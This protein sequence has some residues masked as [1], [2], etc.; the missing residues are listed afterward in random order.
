M[1]K[2]TELKRT[3]TGTD[4]NEEQVD[5]PCPKKVKT[6]EPE[7]EP[8]SSPGPVLDKKKENSECNEEKEATPIKKKGRKRKKMLHAAIRAQMEFYF[9][10]SNLSKDR[11]MQNALKNGPG[12]V[13][14]ASIESQCIALICP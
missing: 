2:Q 10:D 13:A 5:Q 11:F 4:Q 12:K 9:G 14:T 6:L 7:P 3:R 1:S 8:A